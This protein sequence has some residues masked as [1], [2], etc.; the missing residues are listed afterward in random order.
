MQLV[1]EYVPL[2]SLRDYL[3]RH[4]VGLAQLLLFAQQICE[5]G[6]WPLVLE[7]AASFLAWPEGPIRSAHQAPAVGRLPNA[8]SFHSPGISAPSRARLATQSLPILPPLP[9]PLLPFAGLH[10]PS[11]RPRT[12]SSPS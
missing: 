11:C 4:N 1:M 7:P 6:Q 3:P 10:Q 9:P 5:V 12:C 2:G 8:P